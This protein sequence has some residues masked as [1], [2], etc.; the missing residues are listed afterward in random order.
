M[1]DPEYIIDIANAFYKSQVLFTASDCGI[2]TALAEL[3][4]ADFATI[5]A[6][7][8]LDARAARLLLDACVG[9]NLLEKKG[10]T[11]R[12]S[13]A[14]SAFL[15]PGGPGDLS[16]AI[17]YNRDVFDAWGKLPGF[18]KSGAPVENPELHLGQD[19]A[20][21]RAFVL[22]MH[23]RALGIGQLL[24]PYVDLS[25]CK[26]ILDVGGGPGTYSVL[27]AER[28]PGLR[29]TVL[30]LP[31]IIKVA[32]ELIAERDVSDRVSTLPGDYHISEFPGGNDAVLFFGMLHQESPEA[33]RRLLRKAHAALKPGGKV[34]VMDIMTDA[35]HTQPE[36]SA[37]FALNMALTTEN[38]WVFSDAELKT[39]AE[40]SGFADFSLTTLPEPM[41]HWLAVATKE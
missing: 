27:L 29:S 6:H 11:Y 2:F 22:S 41:P 5:A 35:T 25:G 32:E 34:Y 8:R 3:E 15:V 33:I 20:R 24:L 37:L 13:P 4:E 39:W 21:T 31:G 16:H 10:E 7:T 1:T 19:E 30:D 18:M 38:G 9:L 28:Y 40:A 12:N 26:Q 17:R 23:G 36:F 14:V